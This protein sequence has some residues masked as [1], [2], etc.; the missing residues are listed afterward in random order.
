VALSQDA[1]LVAYPALHKG[2]RVEVTG[3][4]LR[5]LQGVV[6]ERGKRD[7]IVLQVLMLGQAVSVEIEASLLQVI[8]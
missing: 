8:S 7:R 1:P 6:E 2:V 5:G 4:P 3:G